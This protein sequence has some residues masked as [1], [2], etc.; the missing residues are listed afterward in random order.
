MLKK[1]PFAHPV[2]QGSLPK[3]HINI[4]QSSLVMFLCNCVSQDCGYGIILFSM[5]FLWFFLVE[6]V[7]TSKGVL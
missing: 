1:M 4:M 6:T 2:Q 5:N 7:N 3:I